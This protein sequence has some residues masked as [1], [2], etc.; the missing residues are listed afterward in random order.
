MVKRN[1][2]CAILRARQ[3]RQ[4][5]PPILQTF[6]PYAVGGPEKPRPRW[7]PVSRSPLL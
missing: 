4:A 5:S 1:T 2:A 7:R 6:Q 3:S